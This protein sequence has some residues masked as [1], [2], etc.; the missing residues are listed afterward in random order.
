MAVTPLPGDEVVLAGGIVVKKGVDGLLYA[1]RVNKYV[2]FAW[3]GF[4]ITDEAFSGFV[5]LERGARATQHSMPNVSRGLRWAKD[6]SKTIGLDKFQCIECQHG[7]RRIDG[8]LRSTVQFAG[9]TFSKGDILEFKDWASPD[10]LKKALSGDKFLKQLTSYIP[11]LGEGNKLRLIF[12]QTQ[13]AEELYK[14]TDRL[15]REGINHLIDIVN[16][17]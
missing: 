13:S 4:R 9:K 16:G 12:R 10:T 5:R 6:M 15:R 7:I 2:R 17:I 3:Y 8:I 1:W 14:L 11:R